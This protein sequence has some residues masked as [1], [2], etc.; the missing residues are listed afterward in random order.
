MPRYH[1]L[2]SC[3]LGICLSNSILFAQIRENSAIFEDP[4]E[5][6]KFTLS[7]QNLAFPEKLTQLSQSEWRNDYTQLRSLQGFTRSHLLYAQ[8]LLRNA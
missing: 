5:P 6:P 3:L 2:L 4:F 8:N 1:F 7:H